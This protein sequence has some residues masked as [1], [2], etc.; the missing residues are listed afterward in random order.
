M[1]LD[2]E[3]TM[4]RA[5]TKR[6]PLLYKKR[7][8]FRCSLV[9]IARQVLLAV[10]Q[11][12][13]VTRLVAGVQLARAADLVRAGEHFLPVGDPA[14]GPRQGEDHGEHAGWN[15]DRLEDD[16]DRKRTRLNSSQ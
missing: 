1:A 5:Q 11:L 6:P 14:H 13:D 4:G 8:P 3:K 16:P 9:P 2:R 15:A 10:F 12:G 7:G